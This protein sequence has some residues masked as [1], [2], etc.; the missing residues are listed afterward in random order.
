MMAVRAAAQVSA[1]NQYAAVVGETV[2]AAREIRRFR[3]T[4]AHLLAL[5]AQAMI[6]MLEGEDR[7]LFRAARLGHWRRRY[8]RFAAKAYALDHVKAWRAGLTGGTP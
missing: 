8:R 3:W 2:D 4:N 5:E 6:H 7:I 1:I